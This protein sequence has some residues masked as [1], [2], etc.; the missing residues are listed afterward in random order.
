MILDDVRKRMT[1][2]MRDK[3]TLTRDVMRVIL[4]ELQAHE[5]RAGSITDEQGH[6]IVRK[7]MKSNEETMGL[8]KDPAV[9]DKLRQENA[10]LTALLPKTMSVDEIV[11]ALA[12]VADAVKAAGNDG[13]ATGVA[14]KHLKSTGAV[15][16]GSDVSLAVKKLRA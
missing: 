4:G 2:A 7:L 1:Q 12:P 10:I 16:Q 14:M 8:A 3:D 9:A 13:Q 11:A 5:T 15:A 6:G